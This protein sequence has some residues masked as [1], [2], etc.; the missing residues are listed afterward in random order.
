MVSTAHV[1]NINNN[2]C[3]LASKS[4]DKYSFS[5]NKTSKKKKKLSYFKLMTGNVN[6]TF[7]G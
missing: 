2:K 6:V 4:D 1:F 7:A 3:F 5:E